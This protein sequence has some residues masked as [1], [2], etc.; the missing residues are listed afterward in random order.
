MAYSSPI[1]IY[2][3]TQREMLNEI[4][5]NFESE[6][7]AIVQTKCVINIDKEELLKALQYDREQ[8]EKGYQDGKM[9][10]QK[11]GQWIDTREQY[12][13]FEFM[14]SNCELLCCTNHYNYCPKCGAKMEVKE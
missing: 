13:E 12:G 1:S 8:Y 14:C 5:K 10:A 6:I 11:T 9:N 4:R 3:E 7:M 2:Q